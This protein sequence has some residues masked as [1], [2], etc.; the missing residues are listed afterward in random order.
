V[1][2]NPVSILPLIF[3]QRWV[4]ADPLDLRGAEVSVYLRGDGLQL[5]GAKCYFWILADGTR[6]HYTGHPLAISDGQWAAEP[7][8]FTL[9]NDEALWHRSWAGDP[10]NP[11]PLDR[12]LAQV[13][14]YGFSFVGFAR[15][16]SGRLCMDEFEIR[17]GGDATS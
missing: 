6:W 5:H 17:R 15:E 7:N 10:R 1:P 4:N 13:E 12:V 11:W 16:V 3:Y 14:S 2:E 8:R 9:H